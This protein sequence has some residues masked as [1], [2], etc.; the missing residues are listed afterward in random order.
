MRVY[1]TSENLVGSEQT[2][3]GKDNDWRYLNFGLLGNL[4]MS[5][6]NVNFY[7]DAIVADWTDATYPLL[8]WETAEGGIVQHSF[9]YNRRR[10]I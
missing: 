1:D 3:T 6:T 9:Y 10:R 8:G 7:W 5:D 2:C 4:D